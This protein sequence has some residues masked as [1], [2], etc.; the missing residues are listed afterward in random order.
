MAVGLPYTPNVN[1]LNFTNYFLPE[2]GFPKYLTNK[3]V[4]N[5][6]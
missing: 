1:K 4:H 6:S 3:C 5:T 2:P